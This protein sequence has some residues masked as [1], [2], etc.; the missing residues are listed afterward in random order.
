MT[1]PAWLLRLTPFDRKLVVVLTLAVL[2]S[3]LLPLRGGKGERVVVTSGDRI[4]F[5]GPL[6]QDRLV[7]VTGPLG[8]TQLKIAGGGIRIISSPCPK[9][10][11]IAMGE[12][13]HRGDLLACLPNE[14]V[15]RVEGGGDKKEGYDLLSR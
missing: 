11:G 1:R 4:V 15:I 10:I 5:V 6:N 13:S 7:D 12:A 14:I 3:F 2:I 9:K 8:I